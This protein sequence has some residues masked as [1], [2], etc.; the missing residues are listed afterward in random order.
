MDMA[1]NCTIVTAKY[2]SIDYL[3]AYVQTTHTIQDLRQH[4]LAHFAFDMVPSIFMILD[5][6]PVDQNGHINRKNLSPPD[7]TYLSVLSQY[8]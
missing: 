3:V 1:T 8:R 7:F 5:T 4:C 2:K 6:L